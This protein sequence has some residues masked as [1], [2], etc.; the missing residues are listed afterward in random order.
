MNSGLTSLSLYS[1]L[2][3]FST[4][5][6]EG[7]LSQGQLEEGGDPS[8]EGGENLSPGAA[9]LP[10]Q[11]NNSREIGIPY[12]V[13]PPISHVGLKIPT[14]YEGDRGVVIR[15]IYQ[16]MAPAT[17]Q[18]LLN[19]KP[20][21]RALYMPSDEEELNSFVIGE[22]T[23]GLHKS[24]LQAVVT[25][26][27]HEVS[28][29][30]YTLFV[31][32][33]PQSQS[34]PM[35]VQEPLDLIRRPKTHHTIDSRAEGFP[36]P[37]YQWFRVIKECSTQR[38]VPIPEAWAAGRTVYSTGSRLHLTRDHKHVGKESFFVRASNAE[39][40]VKSRLVQVASPLPVLAPALKNKGDAK[41]ISINNRA[42]FLAPYPGLSLVGNNA[43]G[44]FDLK[45]DYQLPPPATKKSHCGGI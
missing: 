32:D 1:I 44:K 36:A 8:E 28:S 37:K 14:L 35:F 31:Y 33:S 42:P 7:F 24:T 2:M 10:S 38:V 20:I 13:A 27:D 30:V 11:D 21:F 9:E 15:A 34:R 4:A 45:P 19:G 16:A 43:S 41:F 6:S 26:E 23:K 29:K 3:V 40:S 25:T 18:W 39:G 17:V 12:P 22:V 5:C